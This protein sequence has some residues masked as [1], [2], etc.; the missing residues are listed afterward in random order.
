MSN[1]KRAT[2]YHGTTLRHL[3]S[4]LKSDLR[5]KNSLGGASN[6][7]HNPM[8]VLRVPDGIFV[9]K[10]LLKAFGAASSPAMLT[11]NPTI[12]DLPI[13]LEVVLEDNY[14]FGPDPDYFLAGKG[15]VSGI[16]SSVPES[17]ISELYS[18]LHCDYE[19]GQYS[20]TTHGVAHLILNDKQ[21][22]IPASWIQNIYFPLVDRQLGMNAHD[23]KMCALSMLSNTF[24]LD[25]E[26]DHEKFGLNALKTKWAM[27]GSKP[28]LSRCISKHDIHKL[29]TLTIPEPVIKNTWFGPWDNGLVAMKHVKKYFGEGVQHPLMQ[30][31]LRQAA[32]DQWDFDRI[33]RDRCCEKG[34]LKGFDVNRRVH[35]IRLQHGG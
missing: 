22:I 34:L 33:L 27:D 29:S 16:I 5:P 11:N 19:L 20:W 1:L 8:D 32:S 17:R 3:Q 7:L 21:S 31:L 30:N 18:A 26:E 9:S 24:R 23:L 25:S 2:V 13:V 10:D 35:E 4:I 28:N 6:H 14:T 15:V 12:D